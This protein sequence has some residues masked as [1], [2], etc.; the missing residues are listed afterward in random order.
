[1][2]RIITGLLALG[3]AVAITERQRR[4]RAED[5]LWAEATKPV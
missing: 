5:E 1:M 4:R 3:A 2:R